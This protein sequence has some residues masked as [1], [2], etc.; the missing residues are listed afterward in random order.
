MAR[1]TGYRGVRADQGEPVLVLLDVL[2]GD[3]PAFDRVALFAFGAQLPAMNISVAVSAGVADIGEDHFG[4][5]L[6]AG[7]QRRVQAA[8]GVA[9]FVV[10]EIRHRTNWLP[11]H[12]RMARLAREAEIAVRASCGGLVLLVGCQDKR[13]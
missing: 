13:R 1:L 3:L 5:A 9:G 11:T 8:Q 4:V 10:I 7:G 12:A 6:S 2:N